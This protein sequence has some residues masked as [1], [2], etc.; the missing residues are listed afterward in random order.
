MALSRTSITPALSTG[1]SSNLT[2]GAFTPADGSVLVIIGRTLS[3]DGG[4]FGAATIADSQG[5]TWNSPVIDFNDTSTWQT[6]VRVWYT[7]I[8]TGVS[9]T[10]T[11]SG[12]NTGALIIDGYYWTGQDATTPVGNSASGHSATADGALTVNLPSAAR[13]TSDVVGGLVTICD[14]G[15]V[16]AADPGSGWTELFDNFIDDNLWG[17]TE[18]K[19]GL[20]ITAVPWADVLASTS[21][22]THTGG[23]NWFAF[24]VF[25]AGGGGGDTL[26]GQ[27]WL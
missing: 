26:M 5:L 22:T 8:T 7:V 13:S 12:T 19:T 20:T 25:A 27:A 14:G 23:T 3:S 24:E 1:G 2:T 11:I 17:E 10:V 9:M 6:R 16:L 18:V 4:A 15:G 21:T